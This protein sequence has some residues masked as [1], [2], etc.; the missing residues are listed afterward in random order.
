MGVLPD[1]MMT[2]R[3]ILKCQ[4][5]EP[6]GSCAVCDASPGEATT[7]QK[8]DAL[9]PATKAKYSKA[10][11]FQGVFARFPRAM[12]EI[13]KV[14]KFGTEKHKVR[15]D[16]TSYLDIPDAYA[17]Y[18]NA[19]ARHLVNEAIEGPVNLDPADGG[20]LHAAQ[21]AWDALARL[22]I[23]LRDHELSLTK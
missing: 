18:S 16:D 1:S 13:A 12:K 15:L 10:P 7:D 23:F 4:H 22:E 6:S 9:A 11:V 19:I 2:S 5:G 14:S 8:L 21:A 17:T 3:A 20:M